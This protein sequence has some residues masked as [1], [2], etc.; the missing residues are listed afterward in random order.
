MKRTIPI[1]VLLVAGGVLAAPPRKKSTVIYNPVTDAEA[2]SFTPTPATCEL[3]IVASNQMVWVKYDEQPY[4]HPP[5]YDTT[6][7]MQERVGQRPRRIVRFD[8]RKLPKITGVTPNGSL[9]FEQGEEFIASGD[10]STR[11]SADA[12]TFFLRDIRHTCSFDVASVITPTIFKQRLSEDKAPTFTLP[13]FRKG[14]KKNMRDIEV[15][16]VTGST[17]MWEQ[18]KGD[19]LPSPDQLQDIWPIV[20]WDKAGFTIWDGTQWKEFKW[21]AMK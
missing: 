11:T 15:I 2:F 9:L 8:G 1:L 6:V 4:G 18:L 20:Q 3:H 16:A 21:D 19:T 7:Y 17:L 13:V 14:D 10:A 12:A 5:G